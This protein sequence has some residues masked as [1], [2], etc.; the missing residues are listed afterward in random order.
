M[1]IGPRNRKKLG[2]GHPATGLLCDTLQD[3]YFKLFYKAHNETL[4]EL[5][6]KNVYSRCFNTYPLTKDNSLLLPKDNTRYGIAYTGVVL[7]ITI[8]LN[9]PGFSRTCRNQ[10]GLYC[11]LK[12]ETY[13]R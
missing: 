8:S 5:L 9:K 10:N 6:S 2:T 7:W 1:G 11:R 13:N 4:P 3:G 12:T